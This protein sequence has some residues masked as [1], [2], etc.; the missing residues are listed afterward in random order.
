VVIGLGAIGLLTA[1]ILRANGCRVYGADVDPAAVERATATSSVDECGCLGTDDVEEAVR[2]FSRG[3]GADLVLICASTASSEPVSLAG[4]ISRKRGR[5]VVIGAVGMDLPRPDYYQKELQFSVSCS[6]GPGRYDPSY[7]EWGQ[8]YPIGYVRWTEGRNLEAALDLMA[9]GRISPEKLISHR[10][11]FDHAPQAYEM[12][13][14]RTEPFCG[15]IL[16]YEPHEAQPDPIPDRTAPQRDSGRVG[17]GFVGCGSF[18]QSFLMPSFAS[19]NKCDLVSI[20]TRGGLT[21]VDVSRRVGIGRVVD[22]ADGVIDDPDVGAVVITTRHGQ[23]AELVLASL[24]AHKSVFVEKPLCTTSAQLEELAAVALDLAGSSALP[25]VHVGY[26]R[27]F[28]KAAIACREHFRGRQEPLTMQYRVNAGR[29]PA[30]HWAQHPVEGGGRIIGEVCHFIDLMQFLCGADPVLVQAMTVAA[31]R[32]DV[33]RQDDVALNIRFED[34]SL[35]SILY[36][37]GGAKRVPKEEVTV[38]GGGR[39]AAIHN[40][41]SATLFGSGIKRRVRSGGKGHEPEVQAF[42][43][44]LESGTPPIP[45]S[46]LLATSAA[47]LLV[48][49]SSSDGKT[50][51]VPSWYE[52]AA[53]HV[54]SSGS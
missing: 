17:I 18:A 2:G 28:S 47:T 10:F 43:T 33:P 11:S 49:D 3:V 15:V 52:L 45:M 24:R 1:Q 14:S 30:D 4:R 29:L 48:L 32:Q 42:L 5:V 22:G 31:N 37:S 35:G 13:A 6:Y 8:D 38:H 53:A 51:A 41:R 20:A 39:S 12:I 21:A 26:N 40:F 25:I 44:A 54:S 27:R 36:T 34:G 19:S 9:S 46:S 7:E 23:H 16:E 50:K